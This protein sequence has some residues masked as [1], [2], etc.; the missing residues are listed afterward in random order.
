MKIKNKI[1]TAEPQLFVVS[2]FQVAFVVSPIQ[3]E[4]K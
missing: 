1:I 4:E 3:V 2:L